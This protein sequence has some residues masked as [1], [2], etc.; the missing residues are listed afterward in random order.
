MGHDKCS[1][2]LFIAFNIEL[3]SLFAIDTESLND[4]DIDLIVMIDPRYDDLKISI[5]EIFSYK[6][7]NK[8]VKILLKRYKTYIDLVNNNE[9]YYEHL[10]IMKIARPGRNWILGLNLSY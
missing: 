4:N 10:D 3:L 7:K 6:Q 8:N 2:R 1:L 9:D 5:N